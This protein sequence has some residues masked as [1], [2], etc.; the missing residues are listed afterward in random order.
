MNFKSVTQCV[1]ALL[2]AGPLLAMA[3]APAPAGDA[4]GAGPRGP[5]AGPPRA[6]G[7][8]FR[9][10]AK[11]LIYVTLPGSIERPAMQS[12]VGIVVLDANDNYRFIKRIPTWDYAGAISAEQISGVAA[13]PVTN[14]IYLAARGRLGAFDLATDKLVWSSVE[15]GHCCERPQVT[16]DGKTIVVGADPAWYSYWLKVDAKT[17]KY[18][19]KMDAPMSRGVHNLNLSADGKTAFMSPN[20]KT[21]TISDVQSMQA[22]RTITVPDNIRVFVLN[23]DSTKIFM[24][25]NNFMGY[26]VVDA[27][28]GHI[29]KTVEVTSV[30]WKSKWNVTPRPRIPHG[31]PSHGIALNPE[32]TEV[33]LSDGIFNKI[34]IFSNTADPKEIDTIDTP[35]GSYWLTLGI[36]GKLMYSSS[37]DVI[38]VKTHKIVGALK[39]EYGRPLQSEKMLDITLIDGHAQRVSNQFA[40]GYGDYVTAE[41]L[42]LGPHVTP[43]PGVAP[44]TVTGLETEPNPGLAAATPQVDPPARLFRP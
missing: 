4:P 7:D 26:L 6:P 30:D 27:K 8:N 14:M 29:D 19:G 38:D 12:G 34:H 17:G 3:Q 2:L 37:G 40:N 33:W 24:N 23:K 36:D 35:G 42:G 10:H 18:L 20:G 39:D 43:L 32:E 21:M 28:T 9:P 22:L 11:H 1:A 13:S 16:P 44:V 5:G 15:D 25:Q 41:Q 31:C